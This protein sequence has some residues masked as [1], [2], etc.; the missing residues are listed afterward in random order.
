MSLYSGKQEIAN[1][2]RVKHST[3]GLGVVESQSDTSF[4]GSAVYVR[5]DGMSKCQLSHMCFTEEL[6]VV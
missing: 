3:L 5:F 2:S 4:N 1:G 6:V